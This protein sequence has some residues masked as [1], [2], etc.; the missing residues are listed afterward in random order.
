MLLPAP[1]LVVVHVVDRGRGSRQ[2]GFIIVVVMVVV[3]IVVIVIVGVLVA[4]Q[5]R[6]HTDTSACAQ[7]HPGTALTHTAK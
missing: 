5:C 4:D 7:T 2:V 6:G 1:P 3:V